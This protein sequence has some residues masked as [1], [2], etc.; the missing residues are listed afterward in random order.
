MSNKNWVS[1]T[2]FFAEKWVLAADLSL[3]VI[4]FKR[5]EEHSVDALAIRGDEGRGTLR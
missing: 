3:R 4:E 1:R 2:R 5:F